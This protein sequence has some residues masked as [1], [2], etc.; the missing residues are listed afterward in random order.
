MVCNMARLVLGDVEEA[1]DDLAAATA[2]AAQLQ[3]PAQLWLTHSCHALLVLTAGRLDEADA[4]IRDSYALGQRALPEVALV[5]YALQRSALCDFRGDLELVEPE[6]RSLVAAYPARPVL[7]CA[8]ACIHAR[9]GR[10][11]DAQQGLDELARD[12]TRSLPFDQEWLFGM[13]LLAEACVLVGDSDSASRLYPLL[14]PWAALN[15]VDVA[16]GFRGSV[17]RYLG[18]LAGSTGASAADRHFEDALAHNARMGT[19]PWLART[20]HDYAQM[21]HARNRGDD[22]A[23]AADLA[24]QAAATFADLGMVG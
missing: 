23:R 17:S 11:D 10:T 14:L 22:R 20:Q 19:L 6:I 2:V 13:S 4:R 8:L 12:L 3:Q 5:H 21:L 16:E 24:E 7:R 15:A 9:L 1:T 18:L